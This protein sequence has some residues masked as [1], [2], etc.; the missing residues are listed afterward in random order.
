MVS[1]IALAESVNQFQTTCVNVD[2]ILMITSRSMVVQLSLRFGKTW[3]PFPEFLALLIFGLTYQLLLLY[4]TLA[5]SNTIQVIGLCGY[6]ATMCIYTIIRYFEVQDGKKHLDE[7]L[8]TNF[9]G[10]AAFDLATSKRLAIAV[11]VTTSLS[12]MMLT[13]IGWKLYD[14]F[15]WTIYRKLQANLR[16][17]RMY[18]QFKVGFSP[19]TKRNLWANS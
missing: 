15:Q 12:T 9:G 8:E 19:A 5:Q 13:G 11:A 14:E 10:N 7:I 3:L 1:S 4:D 6:A 18:L 2:G 17:Q 16:L